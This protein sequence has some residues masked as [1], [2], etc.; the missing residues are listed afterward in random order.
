MD[1]LQFI[2][3]DVRADIEVKNNKDK[4]GNSVFHL[5]TN[6]ERLEK[7]MCDIAPVDERQIRKLISSVRRLQKFEIPPMIQEVPELLP[8][9]DKMKYPAEIHGRT[10]SHQIKSHTQGRSGKANEGNLIW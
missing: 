8:L 7:Y 5:Y 10:P 2:N 6:L 3:H 9:K 4:Y 1:S